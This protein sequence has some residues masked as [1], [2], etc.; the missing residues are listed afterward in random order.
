MTRER[1]GERYCLYCCV[2]FRP[3]DYRQKFC[4]AVHQR[5]YNYKR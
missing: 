3:Q 1:Y 4:S 5:N 2:A